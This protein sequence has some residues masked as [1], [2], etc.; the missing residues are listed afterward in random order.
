MQCVARRIVDGRMLHLIKMWLTAAVMEQDE[1]GNWRNL[2]SI[3]GELRKA[4]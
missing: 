2:G 4:E 3:D 1:K